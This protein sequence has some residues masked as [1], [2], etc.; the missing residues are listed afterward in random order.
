MNLVLVFVM[1]FVIVIFMALP[2]GVNIPDKIEKGHASSAPD[3]PKMGLKIVI[4]SLLS[5]LVTII[6]WYI[7]KR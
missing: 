1:A 6:Y 7:V 4:T 5:G 2:I 3:N